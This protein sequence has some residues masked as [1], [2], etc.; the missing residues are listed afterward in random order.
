[1]ARVA[2]IK[3]QAAVQKAPL[4][5][6][7]AGSRRQ[8]GV[9]GAT[10]T[11]P[12]SLTSS[13]LSPRFTHDV[14]LAPYTTLELGGRARHFCRVRDEAGL[15]EA[16]EYGRARGWPL[17]VLGGG[18]NLVIADAGFDGLV[19]EIGLRGRGLERDSEAAGVALLT[20]AAGESWDGLV[21]YSVQQRLAGLEC[22]S[23]IPGRVGAAPIQNI[24]AY[25]QQ[26]SDSLESL[27]VLDCDA[28]EVREMAAAECELGYRHSRFKREPGRHVVLAAR[29]ALRPE[30]APS[31]RYAE[32]QRWL[33]AQAPAGSGRP[34]LA[35]VRRAV[36]AL[37]RAKSMLAE[38]GDENRRSAGSF[39]LNPVVAEAEAERLCEAMLASGLIERADAMPRF[40]AESGKVKLAAAW[41]IERAGFTKGEHRGAVGISSAHALSLVHH[42]GGS[43][44]EL[45]SL[46]REIRDRVRERFGIALR[47]E[48]V[49][50]GFGDDFEF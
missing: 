25:G 9:A 33:D 46:A 32:L 48:P 28:L 3:L 14:E 22:L 18:S 12:P 49:F 8:G 39:F 43:S 2:R 5:A 4:G 45:L 24:G 1:M 38:P 44:A 10:T 40:A 41:L 31:V 11:P 34:E 42:G 21:A 47:P 15:R 19:L 37:R 13:T 30:G 16:V 6:W 20:A 29:F 7:S 36:L 27:R 26:L 17:L 50:V 35:S 23:G